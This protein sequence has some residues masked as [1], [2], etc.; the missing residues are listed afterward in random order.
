LAIKRS[1]RSDGILKALSRLAT[2]RSARSDGIL[3]ALSRL[4]TKRS[5]RKTRIVTACEWG[6]G[7]HFV[8]ASGAWRSMDLL[9]LKGLQAAHGQHQKRGGVGEGMV[10]R[11]VARVAHLAPTDEGGGSW[12]LCGLHAASLS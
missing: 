3:K 1:A 8:I 11:A 9:R 12:D 10:R 7:N 4:A 5:A 2:K 6:L